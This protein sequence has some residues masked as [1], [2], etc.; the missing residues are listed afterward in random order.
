MSEKRSK[1]PLKLVEA[2]PRIQHHETITEIWA[3]FEASQRESILKNIKNS[4]GLQD[5]ITYRSWDSEK[6]QQVI[7]ER[8]L[9]FCK[10][11]LSRLLE[12]H[13]QA[14]LLLPAMGEAEHAPTIT[15]AFTTT[16][17]SDVDETVAHFGHTS[18]YLRPSAVP[19]F[20]FIRTHW[21]DIDLGI[22]STRDHHTLQQQVSDPHARGS[23]AELSPYINPEI[24]RGIA[25]QR[26]AFSVHNQD[27]FN[28]T[29]FPGARQY[30]F[31]DAFMSCGGSL[32]QIQES[33]Q[34]PTIRSA[35][36][37]VY[38]HETVWHELDML[39][40]DQAYKSKTYS[41][42][43]AMESA[44]FEKWVNGEF[45]DQSSPLVPMLE[46]QPLDLKTV[47]EIMYKIHHVVNL[48]RDESFLPPFQRRLKMILAPLLQLDA[49]IIAYKRALEEENKRIRENH[50]LKIKRVLCP[51][52]I[53]G[54]WFDVD[55]LLQ[56]LAAA[57]SMIDQGQSFAA[58]ALD[59]DKIA[60]RMDQLLRGELRDELDR[61]IDGYELLGLQA[62]RD[63]LWIISCG[64]KGKF[65]EV[66]VAADYQQAA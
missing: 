41:E 25:D 8:E 23:I 18:A 28:W 15:F 38:H 57:K 43:E 34:D 59:D 47:K 50:C 36:L 40:K 56:R 48:G 5:L 14:H 21:N 12:I 24:V 35:L 31:A 37:Q 45:D 3:A 33:I 55:T 44:I 20:S 61:P 64:E 2:Q 62:Y 32:E 46:Q 13:Q 49:A 27:E 9:R 42:Q 16:L 39:E 7:L 54:I 63:R 19:L 58:V 4:K 22:A 1:P 17:L 26:S 30:Q 53:D 66:E 29:V 60:G 6:A 11:V 51:E 10:H 65:S 52:A